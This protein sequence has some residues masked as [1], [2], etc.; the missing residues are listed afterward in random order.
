M[1]FLG[2]SR[3][4]REGPR[5]TPRPLARFTAV[6]VA[7]RGCSNTIQSTSSYVRIWHIVRRISRGVFVHF[8]GRSGWWLAVRE[9]NEERR[10]NVE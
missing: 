1:R 4:K 6:N 7:M 9:E 2:P 5:I 8:F 10:A 3:E